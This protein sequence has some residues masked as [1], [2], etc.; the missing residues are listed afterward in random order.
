MLKKSIFQTIL[1]IPFILTKKQKKI[2]LSTL[3]ILSLKN[4]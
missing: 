3:S 2:N 4:I 1:P